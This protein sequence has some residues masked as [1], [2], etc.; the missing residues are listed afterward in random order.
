MV[1]SLNSE[2]KIRGSKCDYLSNSQYMS[3]I[4]MLWKDILSIHTDKILT[5]LIT[6]LF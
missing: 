2:K 3:V 1:I 5:I 6:V 4:F